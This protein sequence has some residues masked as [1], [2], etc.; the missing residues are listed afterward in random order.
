M[1]YI[2]KKHINNRNNDKRNYY[3][4]DTNVSRDI[5]IC[6]NMQSYLENT[7]S[8]LFDKFENLCF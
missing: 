1:S 4:R 5:L 8:I 6:A 7:N 3:V 2:D